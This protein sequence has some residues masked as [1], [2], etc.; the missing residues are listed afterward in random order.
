[1][2]CLSILVDEKQRRN[3]GQPCSLIKDALSAFSSRD[4]DEVLA[5]EAKEKG[6]GDKTEIKRNHPDAT[7]QFASPKTSSPS[8]A[9]R[10]INPWHQ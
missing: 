5:H 9:F 7:P 10:S 8:M 6:N 3:K 1:L 2:T 4:Q